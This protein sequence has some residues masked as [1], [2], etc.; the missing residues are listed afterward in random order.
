[1]RDPAKAILYA[2]ISDLKWLFRGQVRTPAQA[3][4]FAL[5]AWTHLAL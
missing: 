4:A 2:E 5:K 3:E 1:M